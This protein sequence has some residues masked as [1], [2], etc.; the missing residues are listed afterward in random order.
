MSI[1]INPEHREL[2]RVARSFL[3]A[4]G[5]MAASR[6][7]L[8]A[9]DDSL[10]DFW[11]ELVALGWTGLHLPE[12]YGGTGFG[13]PELA[14]I[15][16]E[17][18]RV[19]APGPFLSTALTSMVI[20]ACGDAAQRRTWLPGLAAGAVIGATGLGGALT[21]A[22]DGALHGSAGLV[23]SAE[24]ATLLALAVGDDLVLVASDSP[25][26]VIESR[27]N[28]DSTRRVALVRCDGVLPRE[29]ATLTGAL[30]VAKCLG[31]TFAAAEACGGA[32]ACTDMASEYA[33]LRE[34]F[35]RAIGSFQAVKHH[36]ANMLV[37]TE[38][39]TAA[40]WDA[41]RAGAN[42]DRSP[43]S[44]SCRATRRRPASSSTI[45]SSCII[46]KASRRTPAS[47]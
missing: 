26:V 28:L 34:Q 14:V 3:Q 11:Q 19:V 36:C 2:E 40:A 5:A 29:D 32:W 39:A 9:A 24:A 31:R 8:D 12:E 7:L 20:A 21:R 27:K 33:K 4:R 37:A 43:L 46:W 45:P 17:L 6:Q 10:P 42:D 16:E 15:L 41:A 13:L 18:G 30:R 44:I 38:L 35:G 47:M 1:A 22:A 23:L 25:G